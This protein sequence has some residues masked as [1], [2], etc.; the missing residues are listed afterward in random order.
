[1][2]TYFDAQSHFLAHGGDDG[3]DELLALVKVGLDLLAEVALGDL[4][5]V[6]GSAIGGHEVEETIVNVHLN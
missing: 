6:L 2:K 5:I 3:D 4:D 1:M